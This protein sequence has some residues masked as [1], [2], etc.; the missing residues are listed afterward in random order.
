[1]TRHKTGFTLIELL[2]VIALMGFVLAVTGQMAMG[3]LRTYK[4]QS[5]AAESNIEGILGLE[6]MRRDISS[7]GYGLP[8]EIPDGMTPVGFPALWYL[9]ATDA[10]A[11]PYNDDV[12]PNTPPRAIVSGDNIGMAGIVPGS[13]YLAIKA[14]N[15]AR[16]NTCIRWTYLLNFPPQPVQLQ[17][18]GVPPTETDLA[19]NDLVSIMAFFAPG[20]SVPNRRILANYNVTPAGAL[21]SASP[22]EAR[23]V[24]GIGP[25][26]TP[27]RMPFNRADYYVSTTMF[28]PGRCAPGTGTLVKA[29]VNQAD[30]SFNGTISPVLDCVAD[31][32]VFFGIDV[33]N[34]GT[35][36]GY[37]QSL[38]FG[39]CSVGLPIPLPLTAENIRTLVKEVRVYI[40]AQEGA[41]DT[42]YNNPINPLLVGDPAINATFGMLFGRNFNF[43]VAGIPNWES[44]RWK[45]YTMV[46]QLNLR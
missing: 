22:E 44:Y 6:M 23:L 31:M 28:S 7:A 27:L 2:I 20:S 39:P 9:E 11:T 24:Y 16:N 25:A 4:Q 21:G 29:V 13:D 10:L 43:A 32:Q 26:G 18:W 1:M 40:L 19:P 35:L 17:V 5:K 41:R 37:C 45:V 12:L 34:N 38:I 33:D 46:T 15:V 42:N 36:D 3:M 14:V 30:G 8:W